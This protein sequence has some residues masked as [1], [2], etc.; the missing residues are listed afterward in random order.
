MFKDYYAILEIIPPSS[1]VEI[2]SAFK[3]Q[4]IKFHPDKNP[5]ED[6][7]QIMQEICDAYQ[8]LKN[9][10][11]KSRYDIEYEVFYKSS[12]KAYEI[13]DDVLKQQIEDILFNIKEYSLNVISE[14]REQLKVGANGALNGIRKVLILYI[15]FV[16]VIVGIGCVL[17]IVKI[18][19]DKLN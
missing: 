10:E 7:T 16:A 18:L 3:K 19:S 13:E 17:R 11:T 2:K 6:T 4:A 5:E 1:L 15:K 14:T 12:A 8:I 9:P